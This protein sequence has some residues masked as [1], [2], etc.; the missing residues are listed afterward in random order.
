MQEPI[1]LTKTGLRY[2]VRIHASLVFVTII[3]FAAAGT[4]LIPR[5]WIFVGA[6]FIYY[7][8][9]TAII[10]VYNPELINQRGKRQK[11]KSWDT[12]LMPAYFVVGYYLMA[13]VIGLD[14]GRFHWSYLGNSF[15]VIGLVLYAAGGI[16]NTWA[17]SVNIYFEPKMRIQKERGHTVVTEGPYTLVRHPGYLAGG[18]WEI[19]VPLIVGSVVGLVPVGIACGL[20]LVRTWLE[21]ETLK[22]ELEGYT[23][24]AKKV[25]YRLFPKVW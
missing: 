14:V 18:L 12:V 1:S 2:M 17:Q 5:A 22:K 16:L 19:S 15:L 13:A 11:G 3:L 6:S 23:G 4:I 7:P 24:Y 20:L 9:S 10:Y 8:V 25:K 21:D